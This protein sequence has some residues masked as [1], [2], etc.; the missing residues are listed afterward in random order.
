MKMKK[1]R[2]CRGC[3]WYSTY[4]FNSGFCLRQRDFPTEKT[5]LVIW[6]RYTAY[7]DIFVNIKPVGEC[8]K[9]MTI[10][11]SVYWDK[12]LDHK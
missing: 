6:H 4:N 1:P 9:P 3:R 10:A 2:T 11:E 8:P 12:K 5:K 7:Y